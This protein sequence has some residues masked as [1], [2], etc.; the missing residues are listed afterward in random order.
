VTR[1]LLLVLVLG[2]TAWGQADTARRLTLPE[3]LAQTRKSNRDLKTAR[4]RLD[5]AALGVDQAWVALYPQAAAQGRFTRNYKEV[6]IDPSRFGGS[7]GGGPPPPTIVIQRREQLDVNGNVSVPLLVPWAYPGLTA[8]RASYR[9]AEATY[10]VSDTTV[11]LSA[12]QTFY[13][14]AGTDE[15]LRA[16]HSAVEV[17]RQ[18]WNDAKVRFSAGTVTSV[19]VARAELSLV[20]AQQAERE[21]E[22]ARAQTYR[23][24]GTIAQIDGP[25]A[26]A[27]GDVTPAAINPVDVEGAL[28]LRPEL[29]ALEASLQAAAAQEK[30][31]GF[32]WLPSLSAFGTGRVSNYSGFG[33]DPYFWAVGAS[34]DWVLF[35][36]GLRDVQRKTA[37]AQGR[38]TTEQILQF[39]DTVRDDLANARLQLDT[40]RAAVE[41]ARKSVELAKA[42][43]DLVRVQYESGATTQ[44]N[45]LEAQ[46]NLV[47][48]DVGL[49]QSRFELAIAD[50]GARRAAG[51]FPER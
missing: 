14:A 41:S 46:D 9:S 17:A 30:A 40:K 49:A 35:D 16:R 42:T 44:L 2:G 13:Q 31:S 7:M 36:G 45:L 20:R 33:G 27:P 22:L 8:A 37:H 6:A 21:A 12:A 23:A 26:V 15:V 32:R 50:L 11:L 34:L 18:G 38:E 1:A 24:L 3:V 48:A 47:A 51:T 19:D 28:R 25:F 29:A 5:Q 4:A 10:D 43:L 39:K